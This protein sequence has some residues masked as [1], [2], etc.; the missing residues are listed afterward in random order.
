MHVLLLA[1]TSDLLAALSAELPRRE[2]EAMQI[3]SQLGAV[4]ELSAAIIR[5]DVDLAIARLA[6]PS[7]ADLGLLE[8]TLALRPRTALILV[9]QEPSSDFLLRAMRIGVRE[10]VLPDS[11]GNGLG[12]AIERQ[13]ERQA[14]VAGPPH[15][16]RTLAFLSAKGGG[17]ATFLATNL[18]FALAGRA[19]QVA[20]LDLNLQFGDASLFVSDVPAVR[21]I[22]DVAREVHRLDSSFLE[23]NMMKPQDGYF[24]LAAPDNP[25]RAIDVS[26]EAVERVFSLA[27]SRYD[28]VIV[29]VGRVLDRVTVGALDEV[30][31]VHV[32]IQ[33][34]LPYLHNAKRLIGVL[35]GLGYGQ[36]KIKVVLNR[37]ARGDEI[38][39][40]DIERT[41]GLP[42]DIQIPNSYK[43]VAHA[44]NHGLPLCRHAPRDPVARALNEL[45]G[46]FVPAEARRGGWLNR[47]LRTR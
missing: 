20:L 12:Q 43:A 10:V 41:L 5:D 15:R 4:A 1:P 17:G 6:A 24:V 22:A 18:G 16:A 46:S 21:S 30:D 19:R 8:S 27:R 28:F 3:G 13:L 40:A 47:L 38:S 35:G 29:D 14:T 26:S 34:T 44:I 36:G 45:A 11:P 7:E 31:I 25:A 32:V 39:L 9:C 42:V 37:Y 2:G 23:A 33:S